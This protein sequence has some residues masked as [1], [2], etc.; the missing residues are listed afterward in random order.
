M[1]SVL[2]LETS[3]DSVNWALFQQDELIVE[4]Q[5]EGR[6]SRVLTRSLRDYFSGEKTE[7]SKPDT[8]LVGVGPGS[9]SG[10]RVSVSIAQGLSLGW[11]SKVIPVRSSHGMAHDLN[12]VSC[13]G[14]FADARKREFFFTAYEKGVMTRET[15]LISQDELATYLSKCSLAVSPVP[16]PQVK[17]IEK[18][19]LPTVHA[20]KASSLWSSWREQGTEEGLP[21][22]PIYLRAPLTT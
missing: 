8:I 4:K 1:N 15:S 17:E 10:I 6:A 9:F 3:A 2:V 5:L 11:N 20:P 7:I 16:L 18:S 21:L 22:E 19:E 14:V 12:H 13:L